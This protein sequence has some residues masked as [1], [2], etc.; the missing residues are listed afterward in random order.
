MA[1]RYCFF[2]TQPRHSTIFPPFPMVISE[3]VVYLQQIDSNWLMTKDSLSELTVEERKARFLRL[4]G[5]WADTEEGEEYY[6][7]MKHRNDDRPANRVVK[8]D[9]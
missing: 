9:D 2:A 4:A 5:S 1:Q 7:M 8:L 6:Q 3:N